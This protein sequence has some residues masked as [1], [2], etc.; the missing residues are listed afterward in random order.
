MHA[1]CRAA[2]AAA[3]R[4][5]DAWRAAVTRTNFSYSS[6]SIALDEGAS[7]AVPSSSSSPRRTARSCAADWNSF[8]ARTRPQ[9][10]R[11][12]FN[13]KG[14]AFRFA[15]SNAVVPDGE[16]NSSNGSDSMSTARRNSASSSLQSSSGAGPAGTPP[17]WRVPRTPGASSNSSSTAKTACGYRRTARAKCSV[18][19]M[20]PHSFQ[21]LACMAPGDPDDPRYSASPSSKRNTEALPADPATDALEKASGPVLAGFQSAPD[22]SCTRAILRQ[23]PRLLQ[24]CLPLNHRRSSSSLLPAACR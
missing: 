22:L 23:V 15:W 3:S 2:A 19:D 24:G 20:V 8:D 21:Y 5:N 17:S 7:S 16:S 12:T 4:N 9:S 13:R 10:H 1:R 6:D 18:E 11:S 14:R